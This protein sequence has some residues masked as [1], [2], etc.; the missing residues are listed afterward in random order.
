MVVAQ[1]AYKHLNPVAKARCDALIGVNL[2]GFSSTGT[3]NFVTAAVW[4]DDFKTPLGSSIWHYIDIPFSLD[5]T[6]TS[7]VAPASFDVVQAINLS[8]TSL[9]NST[10]SQ[11]NLAV[12]LRY[13]LHFAGDIAQPLHCSTAVSSNRTAGDF[14]GNTFYL[15]TNAISSWN[16]LHSLWDA[17]GG[18]LTNSIGRPLTAF[19]QGILSNKVATIETHYPYDYTT[20]TTVIPNPMAWAQEGLGLA[21]S[22]AYAGLVQNSSPTTNYLNTVMA[23]TEQ[24]MA[25]GGHRLAD[26]LNT[27]FPPVTVSTRWQGSSTLIFSW[28]S[29]SNTTYKVQWKNQL[30]DPAW[31]DL[32]NLTAKANSITFTTQ[33]SQVQCF[34]RIAQ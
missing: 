27:L 26:L 16:N 2:G 17:G 5:T 28:N 6:P 25:A 4:A 15:T 20:N 30:K 7:G 13:L 22:T 8:I 23:T 11:S 21:Q 33:V 24:R 31:Q 18:L 3:S 1:I 19:G 34:Y 32:T 9:Q 29:F 10:L 12:S 14:G